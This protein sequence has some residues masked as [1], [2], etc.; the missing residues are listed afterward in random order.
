LDVALNSARRNGETEGAAMF[1]TAK[2]GLLFV[3]LVG[4]VIADQTIPALAISVAAAKKCQILTGKAFPPRAAGNPAA[5]SAKGNGRA[6]QA[7]FRKCVENES[8]NSKSTD[9][10]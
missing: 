7:F 2:S 6:Q 8:R 1:L 10:K 9:G 3:L 5:G 4:L